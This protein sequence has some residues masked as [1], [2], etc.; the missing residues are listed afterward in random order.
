MKVSLH[1]DFIGYLERKGWKFLPTDRNNAEKIISTLV[2]ALWYIDPRIQSFEERA[3]HLPFPELRGYC[4]YEHQKGAKP[5]VSIIL[6]FG[7]LKARY[8]IFFSI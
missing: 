8:T 6:Y 4:D 7:P 3:I 2:S 5:M 1:N